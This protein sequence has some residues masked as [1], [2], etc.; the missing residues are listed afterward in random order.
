[1]VSTLSTE[2]KEFLI[3]RFSNELESKAKDLDLAQAG[4]VAEDL[5]MYNAIRMEID[6]FMG[7]VNRMRLI[8]YDELKA[9]E[10]QAVFDV[11]L[12]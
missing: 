11:V 1:M 4:Q 10:Y 5:K 8:P 6:G 7:A 9:D 12:K 3:A 2:I